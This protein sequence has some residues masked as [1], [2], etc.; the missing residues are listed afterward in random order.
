MFGV[1]GGTRIDGIMYRSSRNGDGV[2]YVLFVDNEHCVDGEPEPNDDKELRLLL[3]PCREK[4]VG[5]QLAAWLGDEL[6]G[7]A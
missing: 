6:S 3:P 5:P 7:S 4:V 2:C 1:D